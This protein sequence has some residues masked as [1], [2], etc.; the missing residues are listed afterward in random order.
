MKKIP[1]KLKKIQPAQAAATALAL[2]LV[3]FVSIAFVNLTKAQ[4]EASAASVEAAVRKGV[5]ACYASEG[6]YPPDV[7][8]LE[9][10]YGIHVDEDRYTVRYVIFAE[11]I[12]PDITVIRK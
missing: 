4:E 2:I 3:L 7:A 12:M 9:E 11:N 1:E 6:V 10:H 5:M 8:Y